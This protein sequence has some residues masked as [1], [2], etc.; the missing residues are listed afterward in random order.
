MNDLKKLLDRAEAGD[1]LACADLA[2]RAASLARQVIDLTAE[3]ELARLRQGVQ[4]KRVR[5]IKR[6]ST[7]QEV[8]RGQIQTGRLLSD[9]AD[10]VIYQSEEDATFWVRPTEEFDDITR[11]EKIAALVSPGDVLDG[12][13]QFRAQMP[14]RLRK[15]SDDYFA[16]PASKGGG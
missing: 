14:D 3:A 4:V 8:G 15:A 10:V 13:E 5:H 16:P 2:G 6:G 7:Y 12:A 11:F 9:Y 1:L